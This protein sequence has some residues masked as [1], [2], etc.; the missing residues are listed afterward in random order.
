MKSFLSKLFGA[1]LGLILLCIAVA[2]WWAYHNWQELNRPL[3]SSLRYYEVPR[4][5][6]FH[7]LLSDMA[8]NDLNPAPLFLKAYARINPEAGRIKAGEYA[9]SPDDSAWD[10]LQR[11]QRGQ[12][13]QHAV[14]IREGW[15]VLEM[16]PLFEEAGI[17]DGEE[18]IALA[19]S[20]ELPG[21]FGIESASLEGFLF[22]DTYFFARNA[23]ARRVIDTM[24][25][26]FW[27]NLPDDYAERAENLGLTKWEAITLAS[28]IEKETGKPSERKVI[29]GVF[30]NRL[31]INMR[32]Q[33]DPTVIYGV[34][35]FEGRIRR[36]HLNAHTPYN[37]YRINGL[38]PGPIASPGLE[39]IIAA[40][41]P[42]EVPYYYFV[43]KND[44]SHY[45][46][47]TYREHNA[48]VDLYQRSGSR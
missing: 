44:G 32:L 11:I 18:F 40:V 10:I 30:H 37:T 46:S 20:E 34:E 22:P 14:T 21:E 38:P 4:G 15:S 2:G 48:A 28:I 25:Q 35:D 36:R 23:G 31:R 41:D 16:G 45:F 29:S 6:S 26:R 3:E 42:A 7:T 13:A 8:E 47:T 39:S 12:V 24:V 19:L 9:V 1:F 33:S 43:S 5:T 17:A 27:K